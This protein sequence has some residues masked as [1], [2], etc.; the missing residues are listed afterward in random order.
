MKLRWEWSPR[1]VIS[2]LLIA[3]MITIP[4]VINIAI[5][6]NCDYIRIANT[7]QKCRQRLQSLFLIL[8]KNVGSA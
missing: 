8:F 5:G 1:G 3:G 6:R 7:G 4:F 2:S